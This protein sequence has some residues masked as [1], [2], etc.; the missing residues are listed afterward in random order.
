MAHTR[1]FSTF[2]LQELFNG[3]KNTSKKGV[4]TPVIEL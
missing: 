4:L 2:T 3:I 1:P